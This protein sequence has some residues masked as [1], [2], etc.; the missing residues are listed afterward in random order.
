MAVNI[1][2]E[3]NNNNLKS[4]EKFEKDYYLNKLI[5][6]AISYA[7]VSGLNTFINVM[8]YLKNMKDYDNQFYLFNM[9]YPDS[10]CEIE[11][12]Y[13]L[14]ITWLPFE[15]YDLGELRGN[16][17]ELLSYNILNK[18]YAEC[19]IYKESRVCIVDYISHTWDIIVDDDELYLYECKFSYQS[20]RRKHIDQ[21]IALMNKLNDLNHKVILVFYTPREKINRR[22][23]YL[24]FNTKEKRYAGMIN[25]FNIIDLDDFGRENPFLM[26]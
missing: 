19:S 25:R 21:M 11:Q 3:E 8:F 2:I 22:L 12:I 26:D 5:N 7:S 20:L 16:F 24:Q 23:K 6:Y 13:R 14:F 10:I 17:L 4:K 1:I 18:Q 15:K 9:A